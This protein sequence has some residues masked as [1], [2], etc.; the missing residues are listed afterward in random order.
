[1]G[2]GSITPK[3]SYI[4]QQILQDS[5]PE[6]INLKDMGFMLDIGDN[7]VNFRTKKPLFSQKTTKTTPAT[8][9]RKIQ[10]VVQLYHSIQYQMYTNI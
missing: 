6:D 1:M 3:W 2:E 8:P 5:I 4:V 10:I 9:T 7:P